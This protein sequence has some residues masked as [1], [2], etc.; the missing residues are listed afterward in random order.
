VTPAELARVL[1]AAADEADRIAAEARAERRDWIDQGASPLG[2]RRQIEAVRRRIREGA[3]G[4]AM[5]GR[6]ALLSPEAMAE[7]LERVSVPTRT[8]KPKATGN[9]AAELGLSLVAGGKR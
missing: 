3:P 1:R 9:L 4:A 2:P 7:E 8:A 6:R 5:V